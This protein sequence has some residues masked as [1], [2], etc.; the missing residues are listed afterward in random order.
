[1]LVIPEPF[2]NNPPEVVKEEPAITHEEAPFMVNG[3]VIMSPPLLT[4]VTSVAK[5][6][7]HCAHTS[8]AKDGPKAMAAATRTA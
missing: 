4:F 6:A 8:R 7:V 3:P 5:T 2:P 1:M